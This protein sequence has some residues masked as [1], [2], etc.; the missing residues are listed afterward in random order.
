[1]ARLS[2][3][4]RGLCCWRRL[5]LLLAALQRRQHNR[6]RENTGA[7]HTT[8]PCAAA[9]A[10]HGRFH[11]YAISADCPGT[12]DCI[13][14]DHCL[15]SRLGRVNGHDGMA[16][17][18]AA[19]MHL[20]AACWLTCSKNSTSC[21]LVRLMTIE[22]YQNTLHK[23]SLPRTRCWFAVAACRLCCGCIRFC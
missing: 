11:S 12:R 18:C 8:P 15:R 1:M 3:D 9:S 14:N 20:F 21:S 2:F 23:Y 4:G 5:L 13:T 7:Q 19:G 6:G 10:S 22:L 17:M 16:C